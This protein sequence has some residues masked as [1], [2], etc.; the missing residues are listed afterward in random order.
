M[1]KISTLL[2]SLAGKLELNKGIERKKAV[3]DWEE[4]VG[5]KLA[6]LTVIKG[7]MGAVLIVKVLHPAAAMQLRL[8]K[9]EILKKLNAKLNNAF[10]ED[11][12]IIFRDKIVRRR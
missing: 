7:F 2:S 9:K 8:R 1:D 10:F 5:P 4:I 6:G 12:K 11:I 3:D